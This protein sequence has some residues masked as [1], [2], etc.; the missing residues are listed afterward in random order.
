MNGENSKFRG[1]TWFLASCILPLL[2]GPGGH[3]VG[4][5]FLK[6]FTGQHC[7][8]SAYATALLCTFFHLLNWAKAVVLHVVGK[9]WT[10][11]LSRRTA[12]PDAAAWIKRGTVLRVEVLILRQPVNFSFSFWPQII[13]LIPSS[14]QNMCPQIAH[15]SLLTLF[16]KSLNFQVKFHTALWLLWISSVNVVCPNVYFS[17]IWKRQKFLINP[18]V[19]KEYKVFGL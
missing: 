18:D 14:H 10:C 17:I 9:D 16:N 12:L 5:V 6:M 4:L 8:T 3:P 19:S 13:I 15:T 7:G 1:T 2:L 11:F